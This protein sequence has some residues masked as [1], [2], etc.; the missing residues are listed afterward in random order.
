MA[1]VS[2][3][4]SGNQRSAMAIGVLLIALGLLFLVGQAV[5]LD[6]GV[7]T[8]P[9]YVIMAGLVI[10]ALAFRVGGEPGAGVAAFGS[11]VAVVGVLLL[12]QQATGHWVS[13]A[14]AWALA[15]PGAVGLGI[16]LYGTPVGQPP[17]TSPPRPGSDVTW[18]RASVARSLPRR[19][20][21][22]FSPSF[23]CTT[24]DQ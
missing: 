3:R 15:A 14:Y 8:W 13:W 4:R 22:T 2:A 16:V 1:P 7:P 20:V 18:M 19:N 17:L 23:N 9:L 6:L 5:D 10:F 21:S 12:Y 24:I 11:V